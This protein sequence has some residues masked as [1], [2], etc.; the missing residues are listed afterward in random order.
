MPIGTKIRKKTYNFEI[1]KRYQH[2]SHYRVKERPPI[3]KIKETLKQII[4]GG[5]KDKKEHLTEK[6]PPGGFNFIVF[7][8]F[9][10][11]ALIIL[12][13][14]W[15]FISTQILQPGTGLDQAPEKP[16][17][18]NTIISGE[19]ITT[20]LKNNQKQIA[21]VFIDYDTK[22]IDNYTIDLTTYDQKIPSEVFILAGEK[23][24]ADSYPEFLRTLRYDL[25]KRKITLNDITIKQ[26]E[27]L[28]QGA[29]VVIP[30]GVIPKEMLGVDSLITMDKLAGRGVVVIY[31]GQPF[32][33]ML[34]GTLVIPTPKTIRDNLPIGFDESSSIS[35]TSEVRV[36]QPLYLVG[37]RSG[38]STGVIYGSVSIATKGD[39][40][41]IFFPQTLDGGWRGDYTSAAEDVEKIIYETAW[42]EKSSEHKLYLFDGQTD[43][44]GTKYFFSEP[45][46]N[47]NITVKVDF[48]GYSKTS[49]YPI[50]ETAF[51]RLNLKND[52][53]MFIEF[54]GKI[55]PTNITDNPTRMNAIL[56]EPQAAQPSMSII[57][58]DINKSNA[59]EL[60]QGNVNTQ[61]DRSFDVRI[62][63]DKG[64]YIVKL[65]DDTGYVYT[66][67][68]MKII[69]PEI[70][71][72]GTVH[73][74]PSMYLFSVTRDGVPL[75]LDEITV[76]VDGGE[77]GTYTIQNMDN[78][79]IDVGSF[80][81]NEKLPFGDHEFE[82]TS[83]KLNKKITVTH[84]RTPSPLENPVV[85]L[86][87][88]FTG[89]IIAVGVVF[90]RQDTIYYAID[91]PDFPPTAKT[92]IGMSSD[93][94]I[95]IFDKVNETY[96]WQNTPL[97]AGEIKNGF[98]GVLHKG[99][100]VYITDYNVEFI[101]HE[102]ERR[103][104]VKEAMGYYGRT[105]WGEN[106]GHSMEYLAL[107][108]KL[109]DICV[110]NAVP[111]T[112]ID[113]SK[114]A[115]SVLTLMGQQM[116][117]HFYERTAKSED[118]LKKVLLTI[119]SGIT[120][121]LFKNQFDKNHFTNFIDSSPSIV[122]L[123]L[124]M[125]VDGSSVI[126]HTTDELEKM[127]IEFKSM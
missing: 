92:K 113:E 95:G 7:G 75:K 111:F 106:S 91:I 94:I 110:N 1:K 64:E 93:E 97:T 51:T 80:T 104:L 32:T 68:Y 8:G 108:R 26:L 5:K 10:L 100:P 78:F 42:A 57:I 112:Q 56:K 38:W 119:K 89:G 9:A 46:T 96:R 55:V 11:I 17:I 79:V 107:M 127:L 105:E 60:P 30:S 15:A 99:K 66:Q 101:L 125:E 27:T 87:V 50:Y 31:I 103:E 71:Y 39:G 121:I 124:K 83:G 114:H 24:E 33:K 120:I 4:Q 74:K 58:E 34:N 43:Y 16:E 69:T 14:G 61:S 22:S 59:Q 52:N 48:I 90:A 18:I 63:V 86:V 118:V 81:G 45:F 85:W 88:I 116:Y 54:G 70:E 65:V 12:G 44:N 20:G 29:I 21:A 35:S 77:Y 37:S 115:D 117:L 67:T 123:I 41:F 6:A 3:E 72:T 73:Q 102:L 28:P 13:V 126:Y 40:A 98:K 62:Y 53:Q 19:V 36:Y 76:K 84:Y 122:P 82:F 109:R 23:F 2:V 49:N 25:S 47:P